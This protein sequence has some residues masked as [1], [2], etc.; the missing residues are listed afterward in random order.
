MSKYSSN[1]CEKKSSILDYPQQGLDLSIWNEQGLLRK[2]VKE[3]IQSKL[4]SFLIGQG[5]ANFDEWLIDMLVLGS[6]T[7][8]QYTRKTDLDIHVIIDVSK[9][10][11]LE[12]ST[13]SEDL[14]IPFMND[15]WRRI[16]NTQEKEF[17]FRT[18]HPIEFYFESEEQAF[19]RV[20]DIGKHDGIYSI[21]GNQWLAPP[22]IVEIGFDPEK[23]FA[24]VLKDAEEIAQ[25]FD[26]QIGSIFRD[27]K[28]IDL[29]LEAIKTLSPEN[30]II[31]AEKIKQKLEEVEDEIEKFVEEGVEIKEQRREDYEMVSPQN[32]IFKYLARYGYLYVYRELKKLL[33]D[34]AK[35]TED[36]VEQAIQILKERM[37]SLQ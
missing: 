12:E 28:D 25:N 35:I 34:D 8:Y 32:L 2:S 3:Q 6:L 33:E 21:F 17:V 36:E 5:Y 14:V 4:F 10:I 11:D 30:K 1:E 24:D 22:R 27:L 9:F 37:S 7:S 29:L 18:E 26:L 19:K 16:L 15:Q 31:F 20:E 13:L 23:A